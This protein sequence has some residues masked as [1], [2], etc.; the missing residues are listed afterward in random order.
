MLNTLKAFVALLVL[1][2]APVSLA[3]ANSLM[4]VQE[5]GRQVLQ[6]LDKAM[7]YLVDV[8]EDCERAQADVGRCLC[9]Q[10][11]ALSRVQQELDTALSKHPEWHDKELQYRNSQQGMLA[12]YIP[13]IQPQLDHF[14]AQCMA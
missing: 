6:N 3:Q 7:D 1:T 4:M 12:I 11:H 14:S 13:I 8:V 5:E 10:E 2:I 9:Q